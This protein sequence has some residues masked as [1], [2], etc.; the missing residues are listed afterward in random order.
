MNERAWQ[1]S[2]LE[3]NEDEKSDSSLERKLSELT[4][5]TRREETNNNKHRLIFTWQSRDDDV[6]K[7]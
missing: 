1:N 4:L 3:N 6:H 2:S 5:T 7:K